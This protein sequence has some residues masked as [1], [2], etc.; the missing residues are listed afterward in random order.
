[1]P[2]G[3][4]MEVGSI[5]GS[6]VGVTRAPYKLKRQK[7][8]PTRIRRVAPVRRKTALGKGKVLSLQIL[9]LN[10]LNLGRTDARRPLMLCLIPPKERRMATLFDFATVACFLVLAGA[11]IRLTARLCK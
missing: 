10:G 8:A 11:Y 7:K 4:R 6:K 1:M 2:S 5:R 3:R 9:N